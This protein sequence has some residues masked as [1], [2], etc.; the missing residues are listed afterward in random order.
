MYKSELV[1]SDGGRWWAFAES[2]TGRSHVAAQRPNQD[3]VSL[4][5]APG[6]SSNAIVLA[7]SDGH[8]GE[9][10]C[11]SEHG[12]HF[13]AEEAA[14]GLRDFVAGLDASG[15]PAS[16]ALVDVALQRSCRRILSQWRE[17]IYEDLAVHPLSERELDHAA[18][19]AAMLYGATLVACVV[20]DGYQC[21]LR[22][23]DGDVLS[24]STDGRVIDVFGRDATSVANETTSLA[25]CVAA[26]DPLG[27]RSV[28]ALAPHALRH[29][30][31][32]FELR[33]VNPI[34]AVLASTDGYSN[35]FASA[36]GFHQA[37]IDLE[38]LAKTADGRA[39]LERNLAAWLAETSTEGSGDDI[40]VGLISRAKE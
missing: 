19:N 6:S 35:S 20:A 21:F 38:A 1:S 9:R 15:V 36:S 37:M 2:V 33:D 29:V 3:A 24:L 5:P 31:H 8:G 7:I 27:S 40:T 11:R 4:W 10:Y 12:A 28:E 14:T 34:R 32:R 30:R 17:R 26:I 22:V 25:Q 23:G 18:D 13:A 16:A 39:S